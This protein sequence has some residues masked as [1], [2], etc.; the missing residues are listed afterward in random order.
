M[1]R[2][3]HG[4][5]FYPAARA[6]SPRRTSIALK[7]DVDVEFGRLPGGIRFELP[8]QQRRRAARSNTFERLRAEDV[9][10]GDVAAGVDMDARVDDGRCAAVGNRLFRE[11]PAAR[12]KSPSAGLAA[13]RGAA[14]EGAAAASCTGGGVRVRRPSMADI[15]ATAGAAWAVAPER[16]RWRRG[17]GDGA[18]G[19]GAPAAGRLARVGTA[20]N[21]L[22]Q[23]RAGAGRSVRLVQP[24]LRRGDRSTSGRSAQEAGAPAGRR[25][26]GWCGPGYRPAARG[27]SAAPVGHIAAGGDRA[28]ATRG[29]PGRVRV[30]R[31]G[32][33]PDRPPPAGA[34]RSAAAAMGSSVDRAAAVAR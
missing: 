26:P 21:R 15:G 24:S 13:G 1:A 29:R 7:F 11:S 16:D 33:V 5:R 31:A 32:A 18:R 27:V 25:R 28:S 17:R 30:A 9:D 4:A 19:F 10:A 22:R 23:R 20:G 3:I 12:G 8:A 34:R 2:F 14:S 6:T